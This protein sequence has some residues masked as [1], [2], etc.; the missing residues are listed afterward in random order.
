MSGDSDVTQFVVSRLCGSECLNKEKKKRELVCT[1]SF[2][3]SEISFL[4]DTINTLFCMQLSAGL[5][6]NNHEEV[7]SPLL[8]SF[9][10]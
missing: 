8:R 2:P 10:F 1:L 7:C 3:V 5:F 6:L 9:P 4:Y